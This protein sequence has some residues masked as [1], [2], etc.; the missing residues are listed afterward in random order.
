MAI[1]DKLVSSDDVYAK[2]L[3]AI[4]GRPMV[5]KYAQNRYNKKHTAEEW[6]QIA[7][8]LGKV[9]KDGKKIAKAISQYELDHPLDAA[10]L[11]KQEIFDIIKDDLDVCE[12]A[13][14]WYQS[15]LDN[16]KFL[17][18][19]K[20]AVQRHQTNNNG[21]T[22]QESFD[23]IKDSLLSAIPDGAKLFINQCLIMV[24]ISLSSLLLSSNTNSCILI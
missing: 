17:T 5:Y 20:E 21:M 10:F 3:S 22:K 11:S 8:L 15:Y 13:K 18:D 19:I 12:G 6:E 16:G 14:T 2:W 4:F 1:L 24:T 7:A 23:T 9:P